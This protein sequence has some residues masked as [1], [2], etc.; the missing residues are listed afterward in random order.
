[1]AAQAIEVVGK[2]GKPISN[3]NAIKK[4]LD[5]VDAITP[6]G[7]KVP[8]SELK[9]FKAECGDDLDTLGAQAREELENPTC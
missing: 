9:E 1:M 3:L 4:L 2:N 7:D 5:R 6:N 8:M